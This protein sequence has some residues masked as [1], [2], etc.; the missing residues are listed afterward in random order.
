MYKTGCEGVAYFKLPA[1][2]PNVL[3]GRQLPNVET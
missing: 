2:K 3:S 1:V